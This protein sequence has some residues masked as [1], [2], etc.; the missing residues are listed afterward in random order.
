M[1]ACAPL[2]I[3]EMS[4]LGAPEPPTGKLFEVL[5]VAAE[6]RAKEFLLTNIANRNRIIADCDTLL[7]WFGP[8]RGR[9]SF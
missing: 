3:L 6:S 4:Y 9:G 5:P 1:F 7:W 8:D 2:F